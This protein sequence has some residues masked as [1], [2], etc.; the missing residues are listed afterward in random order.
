MIDI[1]SIDETFSA[2]DFARRAF[3]MIIEENQADK[4]PVIIG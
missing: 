1:I 4:I 3:E 2:G